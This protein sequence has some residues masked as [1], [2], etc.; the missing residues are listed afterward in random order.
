MTVDVLAKLVIL[1]ARVS[2]TSQA[3]RGLS[4]PA[5]FRELRAWAEREGFRVLVEVADTGGKGS[6]RD[7]LERPGIERVYELC[8]QHDVAYVV[9]QDWDRFG[10]ADV[11]SWIARRLAMFSDT[12]LRTPDD[13]NRE[14]DD[15][16]ELI[17]MVKGWES[18]RERRK[19]AKRSRA[20]K[21][22]HIRRGYVVAGHTPTFGF[23]YAGTRKERTYEVEPGHMETVE[24]ILRMVGVEG[25]GVRG[26]KKA[27][28]RE[29]VPTPPNPAKKHPEEGHRWSRQFIRNVISN[30]CYKRHS[31][32]EL[33]VLVEQGY[34]SPDVAA[35]AP[36]PCGIW[37]WNG[38]D[39]EGDKHRVA[40]PICDPGIPRE[41]VDHA[42]KAVENNVPT[43][44]AGDRPW[45]LS[46]GI[47]VCGGCGRRVQAHAVTPRKQRTYFYYECSK[48]MDHGGG[49]CPV[50]VRLNAERTEEAVWR[51]V[52]G[53][54]AD[55]GEMI[56]SLDGLIASEREKLR[57]DPEGDVREL[58]GRLSDLERRRER[59]QDAYLA[60]AF[61]VVELR[62]RQ[63][64][65]DEA[66]RDYERQ[67]DAAEHRGERLRRL[68]DL[69]DRL[70]QRAAIWDGLMEQHPDLS[71]YVVPWE[72]LPPEVQERMTGP[73]PWDNDAFARAQR[74]ALENA[75]PEQRHARYKELELR[76]VALGKDELEISGVF[77][78]ELL[79]IPAP[80]ST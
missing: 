48:Y 25:V 78:A 34:V 4:I 58:R 26:V 46:G 68:E 38:T 18:K 49:V 2:N 36:D 1:Y 57:G 44:K 24:R 11:P 67:L 56:R 23:R 12:R 10:E 29:G 70:R 47:L 45:E 7:D 73:M 5:Q 74:K 80:S 50:S 39:Y 61:S 16:A 33:V 30:D 62:H 15:G 63:E 72:E 69:R 43:S 66:R 17:R 27:L 31:R 22:E 59:A 55:P 40:V 60:G 65:L 13:P 14:D 3:E 21:L 32:E 53:K 54:L 35:R 20:R 28:D 52:S 71:E 9:A 76:V 8:E 79:S 64:E 41:L 77:G 6:K 75:S 19:A 51:F 37:W 42:R